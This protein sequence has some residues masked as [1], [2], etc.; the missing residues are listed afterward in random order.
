MLGMAI[1]VGDTDSSRAPGL[2][3]S[4]QG[5]MNVHHGTLLFVPYNAAAAVVLS[6]LPGVSVT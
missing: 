5:Y 3:F 2:A 1:H 4:F 6:F